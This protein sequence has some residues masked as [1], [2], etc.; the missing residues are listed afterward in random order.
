M[1]RQRARCHNPHCGT[2]TAADVHVQ[3]ND[4]IS[5]GLMKGVVLTLDLIVIFGAGLLGALTMTTSLSWAAT[6][7][8]AGGCCFFLLY[9]FEQRIDAAAIVR[10]QYTCA[11]C[12]KVWGDVTDLPPVA[13]E[14]E[15]GVIAA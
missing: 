7:W 9:L 10:Y 5:V 15:H 8:L 4:D 11:V 6:I 13:M 2:Y 14:P 1:P 3:A 12:G